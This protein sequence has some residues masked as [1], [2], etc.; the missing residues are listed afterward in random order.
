M[1]QLK[2]FKSLV[3]LAQVPPELIEALRLFEQALELQAAELKDPALTV[4]DCLAMKRAGEKATATA[5][6][7]ALEAER[8]L[9]FCLLAMGPK[10]KRP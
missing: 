2:L 8:E 6:R 3:D 10:G 5:R 1:K 4:T 9:G 7:Y